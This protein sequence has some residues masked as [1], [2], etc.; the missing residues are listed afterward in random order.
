MAEKKPLSVL[1]PPAAPGGMDRRTAIRALAG[2]V[3][4]GMTLPAVAESHPLH[5]HV[6][7]P[8]ALAEAEAAVA[9]KDWKPAFLDAHQDETLV[10][11]AEQIVP[12]STSAKVN[13]FVDRLLSVDTQENQRTF[14]NALGAIEGE[15]IARFG[16]PWKSVTAAQQVELLTA[17][18][19]AEPAARDAKGQAA[20][21]TLRNHFDHLK[22]W[23]S[24]AFFSSE[25]GMR[26]LG[27]T[28]N[29]FYASF[30]GCPHPD[31]HR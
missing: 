11:L 17:V 29:V 30:P 21:P 23:I 25:I 24:G 1:Q 31:G 27:W 20:P 14:L 12:G 3:G 18:S 22:G 5:R 28:G 9:A 4:A 26:E 2:G 10:S 19:T 16:R 7:N 13:R 6:A 15:S 8:T